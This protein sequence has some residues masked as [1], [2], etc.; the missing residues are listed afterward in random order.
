MAR[1]GHS[2]KR[3]GAAQQQ[4]DVGPAPSPSLDTD[5]E[6]MGIRYQ[7]CGPHGCGRVIDTTWRQAMRHA[8]EHGGARLEILQTGY[9]SQEEPR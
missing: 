6:T 7:C 1:G 2:R 4:L 8:N 3:R 5:R 9:A